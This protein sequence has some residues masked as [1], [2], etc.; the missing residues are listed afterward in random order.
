MRER[1]PEG[2]RDH[3]GRCHGAENLP[4]PR[5]GR[6]LAI[7]GCRCRR[8]TAPRAGSAQRR[9]TPV[10]SRWRLA[11]QRLSSSG[12]P[13]GVSGDMGGGPGLATRPGQRPAGWRTRCGRQT[14]RGG[15]C[16][17]SP[18]HFSA[19]GEPAA[20]PAGD[21]VVDE[22]QDGRSGDGGEPGGQVEEPLQAVDVEQLG[23]SPAA[24][25]GADDANQAGDDVSIHVPCAE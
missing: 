19:V 17:G 11:V 3:G 13:A 24:E 22:Q 6:G 5:R 21:Q 10:V 18:W 12:G 14:G 8:G 23:G 20:G 16:G 1:E 7:T 4:R 15:L 9:A 2:G 25:Q